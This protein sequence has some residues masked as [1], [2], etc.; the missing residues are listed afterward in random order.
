MTLKTRKKLFRAYIDQSNFALTFL[1]LAHVFAII[2]IAYWV[3]Y[4]TVEFSAVPFTTPTIVPSDQNPP[5]HN[6]IAQKTPTLVFSGKEFMVATL[7]EVSTRSV[8]P[9]KEAI[10]P[11]TPNDLNTLWKKLKVL[12]NQTGSDVLIF[13]APDHIPMKEITTI[14]SKLN[15]F[16][17]DVGDYHTL[18]TKVVLGGEVI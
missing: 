9:H 8:S 16:T 5:T 11:Y 14:L 2:L 10:F 6:S 3:N 12:K 17:D 7:K 15:G 18:F 13:I 1:Y 4:F